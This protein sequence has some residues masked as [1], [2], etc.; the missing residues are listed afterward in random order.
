MKEEVSSLAYSISI[1]IHSLQCLAICASSQSPT[2]WVPTQGNL[3]PQRP[4]YQVPY[5]P[6]P[7][8]NYA[9]EKGQKRKFTPLG[10]SYSILFQKLRKIG[11][12]ESIPPHRLNPN[13]PGAI[14]KLI[15]DGVVVVT[16]D[17]N[18]PNV[19]NNTLPAQNNLVGM[20][21]NDQE[22]KLLGKMGKLV[23]KIGEKDKLLKNLEPVESLSE[24]G[25]NLDTKILCVPGVS[26]WIEVRAEL[27]FV[28]PVQQLPITDSKVIPWNYNKIVVIYRG[29]EIIEVVDEA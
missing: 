10:E 21:Y 8:K 22:Y 9:Q 14:E 27:I 16:D 17:Q 20:I 1:S 2:I 28:K 11:V 26:K 25:V 19:T 5:K 23:R 12:I 18:T 15:D 29:K 4:P 24:E 13:A 7:M 6:P 3:Q